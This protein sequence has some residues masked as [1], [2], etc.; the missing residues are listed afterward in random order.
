M[1]IVAVALALVVLG[2][3]FPAFAQETQ[4]PEAVVE[5]MAFKLMRGVTNAAT[6]I[7][8]IPKQ[9]Y[10]SIRDRGNVGYVVGPLKGFGMAIYRALIGTTETIF[11][12]VP[13]PGYYDPMLEP[14]YVWQ[15]WEERRADAAKP[16]EP[17]T[18]SQSG[19]KSE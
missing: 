8:E 11:F 18:V 4:K 13:Q 10:L 6:S 19:G 7:V 14:E 16:R 1:R 17:E 12:L 5:K 2:T 15:G 3:C 9:S